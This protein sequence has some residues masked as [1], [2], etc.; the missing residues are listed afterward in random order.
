MLSSD[1]APYAIFHTAHGLTRA[2]PRS[3]D[4]VLGTFNI[5]FS[6]QILPSAPTLSLGSS[7]ALSPLK[8]DFLNDSF[9]LG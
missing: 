3:G 5:V 1:S 7:G 2:G 9:P 6:L 8:S 4:I